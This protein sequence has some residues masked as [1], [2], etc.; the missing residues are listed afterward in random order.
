MALLIYPLE[1]SSGKKLNVDLLLEKKYN[2]KSVMVNW[3]PVNSW[4][5]LFKKKYRGIIMVADIY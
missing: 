3:Y 1:I 2:K 5:K 4:L